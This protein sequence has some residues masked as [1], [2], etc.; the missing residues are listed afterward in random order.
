MLDLIIKNAEV[1]DGSGAKAYFADVGLLNGKIT[2]ST[3]EKEAKKVINAEGLTL[4]P[5]FIES[6]SHGDLFLGNCVAMLSKVSQ[7]V[8]T[9]VCG[10]CGQ[11]FFPID[12]RFLDNPTPLNPKEGELP[13]EKFT[14]FDSY[15]EYVNKIPFALNEIFLVGHNALRRSVMGVADREPTE[16]EMKLM[17]ER[18]RFAMDK[19]AAGLSSGLVYIPGVYS[20]TEELVELC[21]VIVPYGGVYATHMRNEAENVVES[22]KEAIYIAEEAGV[23]I[24]IS[25]HKIA[26]IKN[27]GKSLETLRLIDEAAE[28]GL[29][30]MLD[31]YPYEA[32]M[33]SLNVCIPPWHFS[34]GNKAL[35]NKLNDPKTRALMK[36]EMDKEDGG[37]DNF[38]LNSGGFK[39]VFI[40][41]SPNVPEAEGMTVTEYSKKIGKDE[42]EAYFDLMVKN[43]IE[44]KGIYFSMNPEEMEK[45][46]LHE[47]T[48]VG[49]DAL[50]HSL[51]EKGHPRAWGSFIK[52]LRLFVR[53]KSLLSFEEAIKKQTSL[54]AKAWRIKNK[55][56]IKEGYDGDLVLLDKKNL[57]DRASYAD[58]NQKAEGVVA[59]YVNGELVYKDKELTGIYPGKVI[60]RKDGYLQSR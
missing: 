53:E 37:Y 41:T 52:P 19:G 6:H 38:Y 3:E 42:F 23:P 28:R 11:S 17:K 54:T 14:N 2:F 40:S 43:E 4:C 30:I 58:S 25:H 49:S 57:N 9:E 26:G 1:V 27:W 35:I 51:E 13:L 32:S 15:L 33:T 45:I 50:S 24:V 56:L 16:D 29:E 8:T 55:G 47:R 21:K 46:Y 7:G 12:S 59:V 22:V 48:V 10:Q 36:S 44:G 5:G 18:L 39:G 34:E 20:K 60:L 31:L